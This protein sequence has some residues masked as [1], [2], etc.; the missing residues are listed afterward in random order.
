VLGVTDRDVLAMFQ[1][2]SANNDRAARP[3]PEPLPVSRTV[4]R[5]VSVMTRL[6]DHLVRSDY[7]DQTVK[8]ARA[9]EQVDPLTDLIALLRPRAVLWKRLR[10]QGEWALRFAAN[11]DVNFGTVLS[12]RCVLTGAGA[13]VDLSQGDFLLLTAPASFTFGS[14]EAVRPVDG[15]QALRGNDGTVVTIG[16]GPETASVVAGHFVVDSVNDELLLGLLP[17]VLHLVSSSGAAGRI[18]VLLE[19]LG[20]EAT[21]GRR[22]A[23]LVTERLVEVM[24]VEAL[25]EQPFSRSP[26]AAGLLG[27]LADPGVA[28]ALSA[29][30]GDVQRAWTVSELAAAALTSRS[31]LAQRFTTSVGTPPMHYLYAWRMALAKDALVRSDATVSQIAQEV[32][33]HSLSGFSTAFLRHQGLSPARYRRSFNHGRV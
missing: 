15:D 9:S 13:P 16:S 20:D 31:V 4:L 10:G 12:G 18:R 28:A 22:G 27:G 29:L 6:F 21:A 30:Q 8:L 23:A 32:G 14:G 17:G 5:S 26:G 33:Y 2:R 11:R 3:K 24:L 25:R 19:L 7:A 1:P